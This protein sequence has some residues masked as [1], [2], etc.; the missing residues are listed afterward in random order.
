MCIANICCCCCC[1][2]S[3]T[4]GWVRQ[5]CEHSCSERYDSYVP[6]RGHCKSCRQQLMP[7][8]SFR[9][10]VRRVTP[11]LLS[12]VTACPCF[13]CVRTSGMVLGKSEPAAQKVVPG[14]LQLQVCR[15]LACFLVA[16]L[17]WVTLAY[18]K[19]ADKHCVHTKQS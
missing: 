5:C 6:G 11:C 10:D 13:E 8:R 18:C 14:S 9:L 15:T 3:E 2:W 16:V 1:C 19:P 12:I 4:V 17:L 7:Y